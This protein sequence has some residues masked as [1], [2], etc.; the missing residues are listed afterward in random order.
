MEDA[1]FHGWDVIKQAHS[2]I[3]TYLETGEL[4]WADEYALAD[5]RRSAITRASRPVQPQPSG[6]QNKSFQQGNSNRQGRQQF[7]SFSNK[8]GG[9]GKKLI[10]PCLYHNNGICSKKPD[11]EE[12]NV[13]YRHICTQCMAADHTVK[14]CPFL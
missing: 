1:V 13:F 8:T 10:K 2:V 6:T 9:V 12:G 4:T 14:Q 5:R 7:N 11:H 3:L